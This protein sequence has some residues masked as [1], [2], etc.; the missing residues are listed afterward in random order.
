[1]FDAIPEHYVAHD[2]DF[3]YYWVGPHHIYQEKKSVSLSDSL[4]MYYLVYKP[5]LVFVAH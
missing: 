2:R 4:Y 5:I 3:N 1:M